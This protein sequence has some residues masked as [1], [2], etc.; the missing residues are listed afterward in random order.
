CP[1]FGGEPTALV[2]GEAQTP[3]SDLLT[4]DTVLFVNIVDDVALLLVKPGGERDQ[5]KPE[6]MGQ[7][8]HGGEPIRGSV[9]RT[10]G[11]VRCGIGRVFGPNEGARTCARV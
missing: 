1:G 9:H 8:R 4:Q 10:L 6:W 5:D 3:G 7:R 2:V 11:R